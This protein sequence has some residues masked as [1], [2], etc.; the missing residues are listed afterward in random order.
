MSQDIK[1]DEAKEKEGEGFFRRLFDR[2]GHDPS[3]AD[4]HSGRLANPH[5]TWV[6]SRGSFSAVTGCPW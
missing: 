6:I 3:A 5:S 1:K 4:A 2:I